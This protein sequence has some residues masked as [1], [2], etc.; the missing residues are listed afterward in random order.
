MASRSKSTYLRA[1]RLQSLFQDSFSLIPLSNWLPQVRTENA[2]R[3]G[4]IAH[5]LNELL[6]PANY[7][8]TGERDRTGEYL[9]ECGGLKIPFQ[10]LS[11]GYRA[12]LG[13]VG[14]MLFHAN[15]SLPKDQSLRHNRGIVMVD[16]IDL[17]LHPRWQMQVIPTLAKALPNIQFILTSHSPLVA[18]SL[19]WM[20]IITLK[21]NDEKNETDVKRL[22][23]SIHGLDADQVLISDFFGLETS[24]ASEK[25]RRLDELTQMA[26]NGDDDAARRVLEELAHGLEDLT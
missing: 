22:E 13:W 14:D 20:N 26:R 2:P 18:S 21:L 23:Q 25:A 8:F 6:E 5:L 12:F 7:R 11:D 10:G 3:Y 15:Y 24:R 19:E 17:H 4:E 1:Q 16:E 9:F